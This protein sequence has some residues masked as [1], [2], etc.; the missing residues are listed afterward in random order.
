MTEKAR[1]LPK[2]SHE[3]DNM[4]SFPDMVL[5]VEGFLSYSIECRQRYLSH[6]GLD[7][8]KQLGFLGHWGPHLVDFQNLKGPI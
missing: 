4:T 3:W 8:I 2:I 6:L 7:V 1:L 5:S